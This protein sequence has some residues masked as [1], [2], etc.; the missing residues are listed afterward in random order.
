MPP[1]DRTGVFGIS[2]GKGKHSGVKVAVPRKS[3]FEKLNVVS[4][5]SNQSRPNDYASSIVS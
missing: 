3:E 4:Q 5:M 1:T 2:D